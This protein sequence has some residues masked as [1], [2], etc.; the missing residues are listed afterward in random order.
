MLCCL[1]FEINKPK[2]GEDEKSEK[3]VRMLH[4]NENIQEALT[5][6]FYAHVRCNH[7]LEMR[8]VLWVECCTDTTVTRRSCAHG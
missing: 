7:F 3:D 1:G 2:S 6:Y 4:Y 8:G 5:M